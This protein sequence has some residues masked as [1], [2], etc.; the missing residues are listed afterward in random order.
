[1]KKLFL[2][3]ALMLAL[4]TGATF[5]QAVGDFGSVATG[6]WSTAST[7]KQWDGTGFN[8][9]ATTAPTKTSNVWI[10]GGYTVTVSPSP[11]CSTA[12][13]KITENSTLTSSGGNYLGTPVYLIVWGASIDV[14]SGS[15]FG[16]NATDAL[17]ISLSSGAATTLTI[18]GAGTINVCRHRVNTA[19]NF[20]LTIASGT[21][22]QFTY[23]A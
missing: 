16:A 7:W 19:G 3:L 21:T 17:G 23:Q 2:F 12:V 22:V 20:G 9:T 5:A 14:A 10:R 11:V 15:N 6:V 13:L 8:T 1:M 18:S 4:M